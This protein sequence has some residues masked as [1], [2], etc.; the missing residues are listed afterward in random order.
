MMLNLYQ[1]FEEDI[2]AQK[3]VGWVALK[4]SGF[5]S[6]AKRA[7]LLAIGACAGLVLTGCANWLEQTIGTV[8]ENRQGGSA[9]S[10]AQIAAAGEL[11]CN[12]PI[13]GKELADLVKKVLGKKAVSKLKQKFEQGHVKGVKHKLKGLL[14]NASACRIVTS[15]S[16]SP[17]FALAEGLPVEGT[18]LTIPFEAA[19]GEQ[20]TIYDLETTIEGDL[21]WSTLDDGDDFVLMEPV[22]NFGISGVA[23]VFGQELSNDF[24]FMVPSQADENGVVERNF[25]IPAT[26][27]NQIV[28]AD[29]KTTEAYQEMLSDLQTEGLVVD[30]TNVQ[31]LI[32][33]AYGEVVLA[34]EG[35]QTFPAGAGFKINSPNFSS[36]RRTFLVGGKYS[37]VERTKVTVQRNSQPVSVSKVSKV[38]LNR[39]ASLKWKPSWEPIK[40]VKTPY[41]WTQR[42]Q[43]FQEPLSKKIVLPEDVYAE[44]LKVNNEATKIG[45]AAVTYADEKASGTRILLNGFD[46]LDKARVDGF[47]AQAKSILPSLNTSSA[48]TVTFE[49]DYRQVAPLIAGISEAQFQA[50][51]SAMTQ[52]QRDGRFD[53]EYAL[54]LGQGFDK[55]EQAIV[56][57]S[58][59]A[60]V[61]IVRSALRDHL[62][63]SASLQLAGLNRLPTERWAQP[64]FKLEL[65]LRPQDDNPTDFVGINR[66]SF[67]VIW[68]AKSRLAYRTGPGVEPSGPA[69]VT[70][71]EE[72][73]RV[74]KEAIETTPEYFAAL[75]TEALFHFDWDVATFIHQILA[76][77]DVETQAHLLNQMLETILG[78]IKKSPVDPHDSDTDKRSRAGNL[79]GVVGE[80]RAMGHAL[81]T[82]WQIAGIN[83]DLKIG[84]IRVSDA[85][86]VLYHSNLVN[87]EPIL[88]YVQVKTPEDTF[89]PLTRLASTTSKITTWLIS[90]ARY[91][92]NELEK[93]GTHQYAVKDHILQAAVSVLVV[94]YQGPAQETQTMNELATQIKA[95]LEALDPTLAQAGLVPAIMT[96]KDPDGNIMYRCL[97]RCGLSQ[98]TLSEMACNFMGRK[99]CNAQDAEAAGQ[100]PVGG[101]TTSPPAT[102]PLSVIGGPPVTL[103]TTARSGPCF[104]ILAGPSKDIIQDGL[105]C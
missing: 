78:K 80:L 72:A 20:G 84:D 97:T 13:K 77:Y 100:S 101:T 33:E 61:Q 40:K 73:N 44:A 50:W 25:S 79:R 35:T 91:V 66:Q 38:T 42:F 16:S 10:S 24:G 23:S 5:M 34:V 21:S 98:E 69:V 36:A 51:L 60:D 30:E 62:A 68:T 27:V 32:D 104:T 102:Q 45:M 103:N 87:G 47:L 2:V 12:Q 76:R 54:W 19:T 65:P 49:E 41:R 93:Q 59:G 74:L 70:A 39:T 67:T 26:D 9:V 17:A 53:E 90:T 1:S 29:F 55:Y 4:R 94:T 95:Q 28:L 85:D 14:E 3:G 88:A 37:A 86:L 46:N 63:N 57:L 43:K 71:W 89:T 105:K 81:R 8:S 15:N 11:R 75:G 31:V 82:G 99:G 48:L 52:A 83:P 58:G 64:Q 6:L 92:I 96:W 56:Q 7:H 22:E 18:L